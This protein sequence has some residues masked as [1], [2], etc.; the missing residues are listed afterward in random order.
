MPKK[1]RGQRGR[2]QGH[3]CKVCGEYKANEK[4]SGKGHAAHICIACSQLSAAEQAEAM[5]IHRLMNFPIGRLNASD[6][7]WLENR[8][9]DQRPEIAS[10]AKEIYCL[11]FPFAERNARKKRITINKL[12]FELHTMFFDGWG[13]KLP[14][15][16]CFTADR[17]SRILTMTDFDADGVERSMELDSGKM[18]NSMDRSHPG[19]LHVARGL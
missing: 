11:H 3:Y 13:D 18:S 6:R 7:G 16:K 8:L 12:I 17:I 9:H 15:N 14:V 2:P 1:K 5:T 4:F 19:N 10:L